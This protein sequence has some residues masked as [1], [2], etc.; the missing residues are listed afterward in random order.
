MAAQSISS[1]RWA[2]W[3]NWIP[4]AVG[5]LAMYVPTGISLF[6]GYWASD[7][8]SHGPL[9]LAISVWLLYRRW[10]E[11]K[12]QP[13]PPSAPRSY[14]GWVLIALALLLYVF[15]RSQQ[16]IQG[17]SFSLIPLLMGLTLLVYGPKVLRETWFP[18]FF[19]L[20]FIFDDKDLGRERVVGFL[21]HQWAR[22]RDT[23]AIG[24]GL[25]RQKA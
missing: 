2:P 10:S 8:N 5:L 24:S 3:M 17:E 11:T 23:K 19:M 7:D 12:P 21:C 20:F 15:G 14:G 4:L 22:V 6:R 13:L 16:I 18:F 9:V 1:P 25:P